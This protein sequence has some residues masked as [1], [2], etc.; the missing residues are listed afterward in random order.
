MKLFKTLGFVIVFFAITGC[1]KKEN[2]TETDFT[3][4]L[5]IDNPVIVDSV[6]VPELSLQTFG[7][8]QEVEGCSCYFAE[9]KTDF[10]KENFLYVD[11]YGNSAYIKVNGKLIKIP[12][13]EGDFDPSNFNKI[14]E[15]EDYSISM[16]GRKVH[17][18]DET[19][20]FEGVM[21]VKEKKTGREFTSSV[22]GECGC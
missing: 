4:S 8:P 13:E 6:A 1:T 20:Q 19:M 2:V 5:S 3:D 7:F 22:F 10:E 17:E 16:S 9:N 15:N 12:M 14:I 18:G 21:T 11:D